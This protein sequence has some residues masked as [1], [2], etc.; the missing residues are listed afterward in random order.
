M[1]SKSLRDYINLIENAEHGSD[2]KFNRMMGKI[3]RIAKT[4]Q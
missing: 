1:T 4:T 2:P 3:I